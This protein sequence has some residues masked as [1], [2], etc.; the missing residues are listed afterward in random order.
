[1]PIDSEPASMSPRR[2][3]SLTVRKPGHARARRQNKAR[4]PAHL[5]R[6]DSRRGVTASPARSP[7]WEAMTARLLPLK[8][9]P[10]CLTTLH[11]RVTEM[12]LVPIGPLFRQHA[13]HGARPRRV[14][15]QSAAA[16]AGGRR[17]GG[18]M[19]LSSNSSATRSPI[20][21][22]TRS[23]M[24]SNNPPRA[25]T[26]ERILRHNRGPRRHE[27][28]SII[29]RDSG[30]RTR[31]SKSAC[32]PRRRTRIGGP[33][34]DAERDRDLRAL[35]APGLSTRLTPHGALWPWRRHGRR[36]SQHRKRFEGRRNRER[37]GRGTTIRIRL[38]LTVAIIDGF[39]VAWPTN[40]T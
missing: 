22:G 3:N 11:E 30:R 7:P 36:S 6:R 33:K 12:R 34:R 16:G 17:R 40:A 23:I 14:G 5:E 8:I 39:V 27:H 10:A 26:P 9:S 1:M 31:M 32:S 28:G 37:G 19:P 2:P 24:E 21:C 38:P 29:V 35:D 20:S 13:S 4:R 15:E 18:W 25:A